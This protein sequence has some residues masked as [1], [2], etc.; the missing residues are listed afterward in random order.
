MAGTA[1]ANST[2]HARFRATLG[3]RPDLANANPPLRPKAISRYSERKRAIGGEISR[4]DFTS[5]AKAPNTKKR[6]AGSR[7]LFMGP[8][9]S[10]LRPS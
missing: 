8:H 9:P 6:I 3:V 5:P 10:E 1:T 4:L 2:A 7:R